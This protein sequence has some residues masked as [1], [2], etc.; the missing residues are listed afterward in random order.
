[1][2][3]SVMV[4]R[5]FWKVSN[6]F[7]VVSDQGSDPPFIKDVGLLGSCRRGCTVD[8]RWSH[9]KGWLG[10][11]GKIIMYSKLWLRHDFD[12]ESRSV[13]SGCLSQVQFWY[14]AEFSFYSSWWRPKS[15]LSS[16]F[17]TFVDDPLLFAEPLHIMLCHIYQTVTSCSS[18]VPQ[19]QWVSD[20]R[21]TYPGELHSI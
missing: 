10:L 20:R 7:F 16:H 4:Y 5:S 18:Q 8:H 12:P 14:L 6:V 21:R 17:L 1:M 2:C 15:Y 11:V 3:F 13:I 9:H 19:P